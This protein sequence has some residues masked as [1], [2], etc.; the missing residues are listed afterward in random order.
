VSS[1]PLRDALNTL[2][3]RRE[4]DP[5]VLRGWLVDMISGKCDEVAISALLIALIMKGE[6]AGEIAVAAQVLRDHM[7]RWDPGVADVLD[8]CGTGGD[9]L[10]TF[11][12]STATAIVAAGAGVPVVKHGN[13]SVSSRSGS[14]DVLAAL[15][16]HVEGDAEFAR[17]CL[18][19][20]NLA[21]CFAPAFH[22]ALKH[23]GPTRRKLGVPTIFNCVG[24]LANPAG[25]KHQLLG[26]G[27][28]DLLDRMAGALAKLGG[29]HAILV[30]SHDGLDEVSLSAPTAVRVVRGEEIRSFV[31]TPD[32]FDLEPVRLS[33]LAVADAA[34]S[35][36][37][38]REV[39]AGK[40]GPPFRVV[41]ANAAAALF[42]VGKANDLRDGVSLARNAICSG[43]ALGVLDALAPLSPLGSGAGGE[44]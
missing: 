37:V 43:K 18:Q 40:E 8:T 16:V 27:R 9:G 24:P 22:P 42:A 28:L 4:L 2:Y 20:T 30:C 36:A 15:G 13:R 44:G 38:V 25:A 35:A 5:E 29:A 23:V 34:E 14:A 6:S 33:D 12:I 32:D 41:L 31:W 3:D 10:H 26:V 1:H 11:N 7:I 19:K 39:L 17:A 21:F